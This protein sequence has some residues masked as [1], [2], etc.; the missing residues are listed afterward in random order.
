[1]FSKSLHDRDGE[2]QSIDRRRVARQTRD[3]RETRLRGL[4]ENW[5]DEAERRV[6]FLY[7]AARTGAHH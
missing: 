5:I 2:L 4:L 7:E 6:W 1:M 3:K